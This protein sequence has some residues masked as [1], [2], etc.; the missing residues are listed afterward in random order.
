M[1]VEKKKKQVRKKTT[2][3]K[4]NRKNTRKEENNNEN[5]VGEKLTEK[6][7]LFCF[8]F[9]CNDVL[10]GNATLCYNEAYSKDLYNKDQTRKLDEEGKEIYGTSEYDK[11]YNSCSVSG[12]NLLRNIKIQ[13]ENRLLLNSL[14]TDEKVD[15]RLAEIIFT[16]ANK[17]SLNA[18]KEYNKIKGR[19]EEKLSINGMMVNLED[20]DEKIYK[21]IVNKNLKG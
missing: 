4:T 8:H 12:S 7:K 14:L 19:I 18:I 2:R 10:R 13:Q 17:D 16:G 21:K 5:I 1:S 20:E 9:I 11:C 3:N 15:S 6:Q